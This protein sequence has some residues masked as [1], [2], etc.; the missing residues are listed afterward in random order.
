MLSNEPK[1]ARSDDCLESYW[2]GQSV[3]QPL[4]THEAEN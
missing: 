3:P 2:L 1:P 4:R